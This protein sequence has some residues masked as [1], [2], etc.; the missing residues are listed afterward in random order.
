VQRQFARYTRAMHSPFH[1]IREA[2]RGVQARIDSGPYARAVTGQTLSDARRTS[3]LLALHAVYA[4]LEG[5][6]AMCEVP[7]VHT[8][9]P[10]LAAL[11][12]EL[13][14]ELNA[15]G[16]DVRHVDAAVLRALVLAQR[17]R[18]DA[19]HSAAA[20]IGHLYVFQ[21]AELRPLP[22]ANSREA[23]ELDVVLGGE[24]AIAQAVD[25]ATHAL[26]G[27]ETILDVVVSS[28][29]DD[30]LAGALNGEAGSHP[31]PA[32]VREVQAAI[33]AGERTWNDWRYYEARYGERGLR[34]T[35]SD[36]AWLVTL[37]REDGAQARRQI[38]WLGR[39]LATRG[40]PLLLLEQHLG[41]LYT[42][43]ADALPER[44]AGY[45]PLLRAA[46]DLASERTAVLP[47]A[48]AERLARQFAS[49]AGSHATISGL[50]AGR[51]LVAAVVDETRGVTQAVESL[52]R[53]LD[54]PAR[55]S[56]SFRDA[57]RHTLHAARTACRKD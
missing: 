7:E 54:D 36:S 23:A 33:A 8:A 9:L 6:V 5:A 20:L 46:E 42:Q 38:A 50:E 53:W 15:L 37:A 13:E 43:L 16:A 49:A 19:T 52:C 18:R 56:P 30:Q 39:V 11:R 4:E 3:V 25:G 51:L 44:A 34:F 12:A 29:L 27:L 40:M 45:E 35:R 48:A 17:I 57:V 26:E 28:Q 47:D 14:R 32:D 31:V 24:T 10:P 55:V 41:Q 22:R 1:E 21:L 2:T